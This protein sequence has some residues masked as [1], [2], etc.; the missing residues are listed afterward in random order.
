MA[1]RKQKSRKV[2]AVPKRFRSPQAVRGL[3]ETFKR[4]KKLV[5]DPKSLNR[6]ERSLP[7]EFAA[8]FTAQK[9]KFR[10]S[11]LARA[12]A[13]YQKRTK[14]IP[15]DK[16]IVIDTEG[17]RIRKFS[18]NGRVLNTK[19]YMVKVTKKNKVKV[20]NKIDPD[21][22][23]GRRRGKPAPQSL[24]FFN[25]KN[26]AKDKNLYREYREMLKR[27]IQRRA[28]MLRPEELEGITMSLN[29]DLTPFFDRVSSIV[30]RIALNEKAPTTL[31]VEGSMFVLR[32]LDDEEGVVVSFQSDF[33]NTQEFTK[34]VPRGRNKITHDPTT[35]IRSRVHT[36]LA[37]ALQDFGLVSISSVRRIRRLA[38]NRGKSRSE[39]KVKSSSGEVFRWEGRG[40]SDGIVQE[41]TFRVVPAD[42]AEKT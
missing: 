39:W 5:A 21:T 12:L 34:I 29:G 25:V 7:E 35:L 2:Q 13:L 26:L 19:V 14:K 3:I 36:G 37:Q 6:Y 42:Q 16:L 8:I 28:V 40:M 31:V 1:K 32:G 33:I 17:R 30:E 18:K 41:V 24:R 27:S 4:E 11:Q 15:K 10:E 22:I 23:R 9:R 38:M 20:F